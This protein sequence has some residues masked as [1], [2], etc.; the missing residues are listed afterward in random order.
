M[1]TCCRC[2]EDKPLDDFFRRP[3][4]TDG[5]Y[6]FCKDCDYQR[7]KQY[8]FKPRPAIRHDDLRMKMRARMRVWRLVQTGVIP[9]PVDLPCA[10]CGQAARHYDHHLGYD[11]EN[12]TKVEAV[13][14]RCHG[15]RG[16]LR[17]EFQK[18][19]RA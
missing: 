2:G 4:A 12:A 5:R 13:C 8:E 19:T 1:K 3:S 11:D 10:D 7:R 6:S 9:A 16:R 17:G 18:A 15:L 14:T